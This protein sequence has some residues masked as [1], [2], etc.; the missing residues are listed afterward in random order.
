MCKGEQIYYLGIFLFVLVFDFDKRN[1][2]QKV[3]FSVFL[4]S[5]L[6]I[7]LVIENE[8]EDE[9]KYEKRDFNFSY[10]DFFF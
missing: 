8:I 7:W 3:M 6:V 4:K 9:D 5:R 10:V 2:E 1:Y